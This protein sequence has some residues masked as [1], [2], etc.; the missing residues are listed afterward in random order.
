MSVFDSMYGT[1]KDDKIDP[2]YNAPENV[3][4]DKWRNGW[5]E[6]ASFA[7]EGDGQ[8]VKV[9]ESRMPARFYKLQAFD[10]PNSI[11]EINKGFT[12]STGSGHEAGQL[13][14]MMARAIA[15]GMLGRYEE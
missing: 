10:T 5:I 14:F 4:P 3:T 15:E 7:G 9:Y 8:D 1:R 6:V 12:L 2:V 11:G 13:V